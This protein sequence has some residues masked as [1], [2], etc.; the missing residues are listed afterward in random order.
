MFALHFLLIRN[1]SNHTRVEVVATLKVHSVAYGSEMSHT[2]R[3]NNTNF[4]QTVTVYIVTENEESNPSTES[5]KSKPSQE[6][7]SS[8]GQRPRGL[9]YFYFTAS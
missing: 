5:S 2:Q 1:H 3:P 8:Q 7:N 4:L 6:E 9:S